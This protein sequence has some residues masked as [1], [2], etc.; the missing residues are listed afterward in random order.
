MVEWIAKGIGELGYFGVALLMFV[1]NLFPPIPSEVVMPLA[2]F[3]A[4]R[5]D[6]TL[7]GVILA[8]SAGSLLGAAPW[9]LAGR[10]LGEHRLKHLAERHGR[11]VAISPE[12][13]ERAVGWFRRH[14]PVAVL[15]GRLVPG[16]RTFISTPAGVARMPIAPFVACS[17]IGTM[18]WS[19]LLAIAGYGL[20][21]RYDAVAR[22]VDLI[23]QAVFVLMAVGYGVGVWRRRRRGS[24]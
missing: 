16:V 1:E 20:E 8:G 17:A 23:A 4:A 9:Y 12:D 11:W 6:L 5:G 13:I 21:S 14:G 3:A 2:G 18:A 15:A 22:H 19:S 10:I 7:T 24:A